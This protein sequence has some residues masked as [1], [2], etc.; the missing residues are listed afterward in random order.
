MARSRKADIYD[1][2]GKPPALLNGLTKAQTIALKHYIEDITSR[3]YRIAYDNGAVEGFCKVSM[4]A[5][6]ELKMQRE[7]MLRGG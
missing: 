3:V 4:I 7:R 1:V 2:W 6:N 5:T